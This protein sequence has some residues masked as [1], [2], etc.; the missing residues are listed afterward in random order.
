MNLKIAITLGSAR[1][2]VLKT[3]LKRPSFVPLSANLTQDKKHGKFVSRSRGKG[4]GVEI[5]THCNKINYVR[6]SG[7]SGKYSASVCGR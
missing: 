3:Y 1:Q 7:T 2:N 5:Q 4:A 6:K